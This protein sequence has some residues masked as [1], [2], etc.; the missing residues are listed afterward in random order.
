[1]LAETMLNCKADTR[2]C[3]VVLQLL[4]RPKYI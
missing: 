3:C 4:Q 2:R 1:M